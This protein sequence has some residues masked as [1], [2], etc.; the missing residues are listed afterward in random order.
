MPREW[1]RDPFFTF[2][3]RERNDGLGDV[4]A[5]VG[6]ANYTISK[7]RIKISM[8]VGYYQLPDVKNYTLNKYGLPSYTQ[9]NLDIRYTFGKVLQGLEAQFLMAGKS[10]IGE[11]YN[12]SKFVINKVN[13]EQYNFV[14][15]YHF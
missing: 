10:K 3:P 1:G 14:L 6:K 5:I 2:L 13:M 9:I 4:S 7:T 15:N 11:T 8:G 12:N